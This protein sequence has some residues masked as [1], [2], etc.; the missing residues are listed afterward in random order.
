MTHKLCTFNVKG[1]GETKKRRQIF[2]WLQQ[3][4]YNICFLQEMH[5]KESDYEKWAKEWGKKI[6]LSGNSSNS[7]GIGI[8]L[9]NAINVV[10]HS[11]D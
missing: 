10:E 5:C 7:K 1:L 11:F 2:N 6:Y 8:L 3:N 9:D 4:K